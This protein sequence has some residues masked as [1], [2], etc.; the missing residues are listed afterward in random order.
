[1]GRAAQ[2]QV[3]EAAPLMVADRSIGALI[4]RFYANHEV[5]EQEEADPDAA[6]GAGRAG[7]RSR[8]PVRH[9]ECRTRAR[10]RAARDHPGAGRQPGRAARARNGG[11]LLARGCSMRRT[12]RVWLVDAERRA[13]LRGGA[14]ASSIPRRSADVWR[15]TAPRAGPPGSRSSTSK[16]RPPTELVLQS[17]VRRAHRAGRLPGRGPVARGRIA[18]RA[19]SHAPDRPPL[20]PGR[21]AAAGQPVERRRRRREQRAHPRRGRSS[22]RSRVGQIRVA[23]PLGLRSDRLGR[24][25]LRRRRRGHQ[26]QRRGRGDPR[27]Q[28]GRRCSA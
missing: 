8:A 19:R 12:P 13:E 24:A 10:A 5:S 9:L 22:A 1:M 23:A 17:R 14:T 28:P 16:T 3:V 7:A 27:S 15:A 11:R 25:G 20:Q 26:R 21:G 2:P 6:G 18:R 4:V